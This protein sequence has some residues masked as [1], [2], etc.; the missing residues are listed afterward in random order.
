MSNLAPSLLVPNA[1]QVNLIPPEVASRKA[2]GRAR[3]LVLI[4]LLLFVAFLMAGFYLTNS[5]KVAAEQD[6]AMA[7]KAGDDLNAE[8]AKYAEVPLV[9]TQLANAASARLYAGSTEIRWASLLLRMRAVMPAG[10]D[11]S[12]TGFTVS[13]PSA[14]VAPIVG[15]FA[16]PGVGTMTFSGTSPTYP[17]VVALVRAIDSVAGLAGAQIPGVSRVATETEV[18]YTFSGTATVTVEAFDSRFTDEWFVA[19]SRE[20]ADDYLDELVAWLAADVVLAQGNVEAGLPGA[21][22]AY[23]DVLDVQEA[24]AEARDTFTSILEVVE[25]AE[26]NLEIAALAEAYGEE[27]ASALLADAQTAVDTLAPAMEQLTSVVLAIRSSS[28]ELDTVSKRVAAAEALVAAKQEQLVAAEEALAAA[29]ADRVALQ[30]DV[31][32]REVLV[33]EA[34]DVLEAEKPAV[35][36]AEAAVAAAFGALASAIADA[37]TAVT[38]ANVTVALKPSK[39]PPVPIAPAPS[40][41]PTASPSPS[42]TQEGEA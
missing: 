31:A 19:R 4:V 17:D 10:I 27:G 5:Q 34:E 6:L 42:A 26:A 21:S 30:A 2:A 12:A 9:Q 14:P 36:P 3:G 33:S 28:Q 18:K 16:S 32:Y 40:P 38:T 35:A 11:I 41:S 15:P 7:V 8:I 13:S 22:A 20:I 29:A 24:V 23:A 37:E 39:R 1:P 25:I